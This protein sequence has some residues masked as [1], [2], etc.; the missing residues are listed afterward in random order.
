MGNLEGKRSLGR[1]RRMWYNNIKTDFKEIE[2]EGM[3]WINLAQVRDSWR[4][5]VKTA[6][7]LCIL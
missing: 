5:V 7:N 3:E 6:M 1:P 2:W 4:S